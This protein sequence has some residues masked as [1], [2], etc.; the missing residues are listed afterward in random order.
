MLRAGSPNPRAWA[1]MGAELIGMHATVLQLRFIASNNDRVV[2]Q[3]EMDDSVMLATWGSNARALGSATPMLTRLS[4]GQGLTS[5]RWPSC[6]PNSDVPERA[7]QAVGGWL[8][9]P[10]SATRVFPDGCPV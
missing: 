4:A 5:L 1:S 6:F 3:A 2:M 9:W 8:V 10:H 7:D